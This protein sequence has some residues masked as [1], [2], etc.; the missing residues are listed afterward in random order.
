MVLHSCVYIAQDTFVSLQLTESYRLAAMGSLKDTASEQQRDPIKAG[1]PRIG[2]LYSDII[3]ISEGQ[4]FKVH[5]LILDL[6]SPN[7]FGKSFSGWSSDAQT[8]KLEV[9]DARAEIVK[10]ML[11]FF[12]KSTYEVPESSSPLLFH[13]EVYELAGRYQAQALLDES[14]RKFETGCLNGVWD[15]SDFIDA[16][17]F[18]EGNVLMSIKALRAAVVSAM[19]AKLEKLLLNHD[20]ADLLSEHK[21]LNVELL[22]KMSSEP[23]VYLMQQQHQGDWQRSGKRGSQRNG[24][25]RRAA[26]SSPEAG[27][28]GR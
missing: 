21:F 9:K 18:M 23:P 27:I 20:F 25:A 4:H 13:L 1:L 5:R 2:D 3:L 6:H 10:A 24:G 15:P 11:D 7:V 12:Y 8:Q 22:R 17:R 28:S 19:K 14:F 16:V 26:H